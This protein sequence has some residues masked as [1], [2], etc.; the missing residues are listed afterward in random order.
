MTFRFP[1]G[2]WLGKGIDDGSLERILV[3][4]LLTCQPEVDE[5][6][7]RTP[8]LQQSPSV[9][10]R[11]VTISPNNKPSKWEEGLGP[12]ATQ[13][14]NVGRSLGTLMWESRPSLCS[15][16]R[17]HFCQQSSLRYLSPSSHESVCVCVC[18]SGLKGGVT[19]LRGLE[20]EGRG[21]AAWPRS[22]VLFIYDSRE[23]RGLPSGLV[24]PCSWASQPSLGP[25]LVARS[26]RVKWKINLTSLS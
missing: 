16:L 6:P 3:G 2:R 25:F 23:E 8:P 26:S 21:H 7:C 14:G 19:L 18:V 5:R 20:G 4:E 22:F 15:C 12:D 9:I 1:C 13:V 11:L 17:N 24:L 10:R